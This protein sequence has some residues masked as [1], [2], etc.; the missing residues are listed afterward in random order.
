MSVPNVPVPLE[1]IGEPTALPPGSREPGLI[2]RIRCY[3]Q[4]HETL[5]WWCHSAWSFMF[6]IGVMVLGAKKPTYARII[7]FHIGFIWATSLFLPV[8]RGL[9]RLSPVW[10]ERLRLL[11]NYFNRN[12]YQQLLFFVLPIYYA[13]TTIPSRNVVFLAVLVL[14]AVLSTLDVVYDRYLSVLWPL[15]ALF[16]AFNAFVSVNVMLLVL[17]AIR[18]DIAL[19]LSTLPA[20]AIFVSMLYRFAE[21]RGQSLGIVTAAVVCFLI[22]VVH[23]STPF[24]PPV[25][26][27]LGDASFGTAVIRRTIL[28]P[29]SQLP[30]NYRG[31]LAA[32]TPI[33]APFG[34]TAKVR[35][36]WYRDGKLIPSADKESGRYLAI[37]GGR[38]EGF[39]VWSVRTMQPGWD[40][41]RI[42]VDVEMSSGQLIGRAMLRRATE[43]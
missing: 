8:L 16:L 5:L 2:P 18:N 10:R 6:G 34:L 7:L 15:T 27:S 31:R 35:H 17:F 38:K 14:S 20:A 32:L 39:R 25:M 12:F 13:S 28:N 29:V 42:W 23:V 21:L 24:V 9:P 4:E 3:L 43:E 11:I 26:V 41:K 19:Y 36:T 22:F 30:A 33:K 37:S 40:P 1:K